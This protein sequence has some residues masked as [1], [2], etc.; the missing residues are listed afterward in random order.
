MGASH[1]R[2]GLAWHKRFSRGVKKAARYATSKEGKKKFQDF[3][4]I[5]KDAKQLL[6][7]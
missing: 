2:G 5:V 1:R 7:D 3:K 6:K 4:K